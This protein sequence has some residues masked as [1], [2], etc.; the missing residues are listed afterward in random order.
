MRNPLDGKSLRLMGDDEVSGTASHF[1]IDTSSFT[2]ENDSRQDFFAMSM[3]LVQIR[4]FLS[5]RRLS[6][7]VKK[8]R[9]VVGSKSS[10]QHC[11][12]PFF[13]LSRSH[14]RE[15][16]SNL[17]RFSVFQL[18]HDNVRALPLLLNPGRYHVTRHD[19][20]KNTLVF[21]D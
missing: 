7:T 19:A 6:R 9:L 21:R 16:G 2:R 20:S 4:I 8:D 12:A 3:P 1:I 15:R 11:R 14:P 5:R 10:D 13:F 17:F 18:F